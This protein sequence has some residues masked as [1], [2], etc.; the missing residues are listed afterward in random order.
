MRVNKKFYSKKKK[1]IYTFISCASMHHA[2]MKLRIYRFYFVLIH[3]VEESRYDTLYLFLDI[4][5]LRP[6]KKFKKILY[7]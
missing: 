6:K 5:L 3:R 4:L 7:F 2:R 1:K